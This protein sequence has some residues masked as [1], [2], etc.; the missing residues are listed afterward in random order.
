M[1]GRIVAFD[2]RY[3]RQINNLEWLAK[4]EHRT[5][6]FSIG[7]NF[8][9]ALIRRFLF[10]FFRSILLHITYMESKDTRYSIVSSFSHV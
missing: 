10:P 4:K 5:A 1:H 8:I 7:R 3:M 9:V 6:R 2:A